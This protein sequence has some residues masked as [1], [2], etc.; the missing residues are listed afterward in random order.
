LVGGNN[1]KDAIMLEAHLRSGNDYFVTEDKDD[2][3]S[4][5]S[6]LE[7]HFNIKVISPTELEILLS[8]LTAAKH[9]T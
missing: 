6:E 4:K 8:D 5:R 2:I 7:E 1:V 9:A 3:L